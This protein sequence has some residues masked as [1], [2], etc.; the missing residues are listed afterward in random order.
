MDD[1]TTRARVPDGQ[2]RAETDSCLSPLGYAK[3]PG[4]S[5][6]ACVRNDRHD[7]P[8]IEKEQY[9]RAIAD[10]TNDW[11][12][13]I[14]LDGQL[15][16][17]NPA[18]ERV[19]GYSV[20][21][22]MAMADFPLPLVPVEDRKA[23]QKALRR[24][25]AER[26]SG[27]DRPVRFRRKDG[28]VRW[29]SVSW[30]PIY[31]DD[32]FCLGIRSSVRDITDRVKVAEE[33][34]AAK[35]VAEAACRSKGVFLANL[36]HELRTPIMALLAAAEMLGH[37][38]SDQQHASSQRDIIVRNSRHLLSLFDGLFDAAR[39]EGGTFDIRPTTCSVL[40]ILADTRSI[41]RP[42]HDNPEVAFKLRCEGSIPAT[43][44]TDP[45][46][47]KQAYANLIGNAL[48]F[49]RRGHVHATVRVLTSGPD[50]A[51]ELTVEDT[52]CGISQVDQTRVFEMF[53]Q[54]QRPASGGLGGIGVGLPMA[55]WIAE[56]LGG[57]LSLTSHP[58]E[59]STFTMRVATGPIDN[60]SWITPDLD[61]LP[62]P[63]RPHA[64]GRAPSHRLQGTVLVADDSADLREI[65]TLALSRAGATVTTAATGE[66]A[67]QAAMREPFDLALLDMR[68]PVMSGLTAATM[69]RRHG[70]RSPLV[71]LTASTSSDDRKR[72][73]DAGFDDLWRKPIALAEL[74]DRVSA[75][76]ENQDRACESTMPPTPSGGFGED[77]R[78]AA[79]VTEFVADLPNRFRRIDDAIASNDMLTAREGLHQLA[80]TGGTL[81]FGALSAQAA[82]ALARIRQADVVAIDEELRS[83]DA[84][85]RD[86]ATDGAAATA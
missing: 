58:G 40:D 73:M 11:E 77:S 31:D 2:P 55:R 60:V 71:A 30:Q 18:V 29:G 42:L 53:E 76:L 15:I 1:R 82:K 65:I 79:I 43:I 63:S 54:A 16:W 49:T 41:T 21:A 23:A 35:E 33:L 57:S 61:A 83:L 86:I 5:N 80:G 36:T 52:G 85:I 38:P 25:I 81:G 8:H 17:V 4:P 59:G 72:L 50:P 26:T 3:Q 45:V 22:C 69:L 75:F 70:Y 6:E 12:N 20:H 46:R 51:L 44:H 47:V 13:W 10:Y 34:E 32:G 24:A 66:E 62:P 7:R 48:K 84:L 56:E 78:Y 64:R 68:M 39:V 27:T 9:F 14:G 19:A 74:L 28:S 67:F 37:E